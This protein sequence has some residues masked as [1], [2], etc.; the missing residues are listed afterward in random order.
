MFI[1]NP[2]FAHAS[3]CLSCA[4]LPSSHQGRTPNLLL[5]RAFKLEGSRTSGEAG[6]PIKEEDREDLEDDSVEDDVAWGQEPLQ[7]PS[8][9]EIQRRLAQQHQLGDVPARRGPGDSS[10]TRTKE[11][12]VVEAVEEEDE[13]RADRRSGGNV[14]VYDHET[15]KIEAE[16]DGV[17]TMTVATSACHPRVPPSLHRL[18]PAL[19]ATSTEWRGDGGAMASK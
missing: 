1:L 18:L 11:G 12:D 9:L 17:D 14:G 10:I 2:D 13:G 7:V 6:P 3:L 19:P 5:P 16:E 8:L 4:F 15:V